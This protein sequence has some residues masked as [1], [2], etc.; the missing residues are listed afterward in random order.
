MPYC[1]TPGPGGP[2]FFSN[3]ALAGLLILRIDKGFSR[4]ALYLG[5]CIH[6]SGSCNGTLYI[7]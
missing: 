3:K 6:N 7:L 5:T 1:G 4:G 2:Y